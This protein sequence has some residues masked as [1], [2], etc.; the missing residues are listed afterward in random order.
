ML[1]NCCLLNYKSEALIIGTANQLRT[2]NSAITSVCVADVQLPVAD[3]I[4][5]LGVM[6][7]HRLAF[8][9]HVMAVTQS[10]NFHA[11]AIHHIRHLLSTDLAQTLACTLI[12]TGLDYCNSVLYGAPVSSIQKLQ[13][14][15]NNTARI[16]L[17]AP[18]R[19]HAKP[20]MRQLHWL[21]VQHRIDTKVSVL[22]Y[23]TLNMSVPQYLSQR[24]NRRVNAD[25][26]LDGHATAHPTVHLYRLRET[27]FSMCRAVCLELTSRVV[28]ESN[29][30]SVFKSRLKTF[31]FLRYFG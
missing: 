15:Q 14:V 19:S 9:K 5:V 24:I 7:D 27:F 29:S 6:L 11:Q 10:C 16:V 25:T 21:L 26:T 2:A 3:E 22:T 18:R 28:I 8:D 1:A 30:L 13:H 17:Q 12:L 4:K 31:L 23:K 20:L